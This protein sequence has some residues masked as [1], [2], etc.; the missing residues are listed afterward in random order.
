MRRQRA[1]RQ[2]PAA[3]WGS[4]ADPRA[5]RSRDTAAARVVQPTL[6]TAQPARP[7]YSPGPVS[8]KGLVELD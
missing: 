4:S 1:R 5:V 8:G 6:Y 3:G 2:R 7:R